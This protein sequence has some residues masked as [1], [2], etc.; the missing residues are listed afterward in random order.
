MIVGVVLLFVYTLPPLPR[1][2]V[3]RMELNYSPFI[4]TEFTNT[5]SLFVLVLGAGADYDPSFLPSQLLSS[6]QAVRLAEGIRVARLLPNAVLVTSAHVRHSPLSQ[7]ELSRRAARSWGYTERPILLQEEPTTTC[8]EAR[9][10]LDAHGPGT[11]VVLVTSATHMRRAMAYFTALGA[12]PIA[13]P[14]DFRVKQ[15]PYHPIHSANAL[16]SW[17]HLHWLDEL[18]K[19][20][21][22]YR[23]GPLC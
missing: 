7:A 19:E 3:E 14:T 1:Y 15:N 6:T 13:A 12:E 17:K 21:L 9:A 18:L 23:L 22:A 4:S 2:L 8:E 16:P 11:R 20:A 10:F 5:D